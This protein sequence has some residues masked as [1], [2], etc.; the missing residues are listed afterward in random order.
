MAIIY[1]IVI[2]NTE[3]CNIFR[4][5]CQFLVVMRRNML[6]ILECNTFNVFPTNCKIHSFYAAACFGHKSQP[7]SAP[8][9]ALGYMQRDMQ[10]VSPK[11]C[12]II[13]QLIN[14]Y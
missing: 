8:Y 4:H 6:R 14:N 5:S 1:S 10:L 11:F 9:S 12:G 3:M 2:L 13:P 7:S